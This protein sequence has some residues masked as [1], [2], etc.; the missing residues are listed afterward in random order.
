M[1]EV[2]SFAPE[3]DNPY[4][5]EHSPF[6]V[7]QSTTA[8]DPN[9]LG[10][11]IDPT[12]GASGKKLNEHYLPLAIYGY[13]PVKVTTENGAIKRGDGLTSSSMAGVAM[14]ATQACK[15]IGY[16]LEDAEADGT[17]QVFANL[18]E[19]AGPDAAEL[20]AEVEALKQ[21][22]AELKQASA[23]QTTTP[24]EAVL[25]GAVL[26]AGLVVVRRADR[27]GLK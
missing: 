13:F 1:A 25:L 23:A 3:T 22:V 26:V 17:I 24:R 18:G 12:S 6:V 8:C 20:R 5:D 15:I 19:S 10:F 7:T 11:I 9:L 4:G 16:A 14:K 21:S 2:V 27:G